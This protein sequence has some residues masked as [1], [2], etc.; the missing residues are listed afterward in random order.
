MLVILGIEE[1]VGRHG[2]VVRVKFRR[3]GLWLIY[4]GGKVDV[5]GVGR[6]ISVFHHEIKKNKRSPLFLLRHSL[7]ATRDRVSTKSRDDTRRVGR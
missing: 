2:V 4:Q 5:V 7:G 3:G 1:S 6:W